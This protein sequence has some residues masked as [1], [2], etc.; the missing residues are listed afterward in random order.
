MHYVIG[1]VHG[2]FSDM[3]SLITKI[4][5]MDESAQFIFVG[6]LIDRGP[7]VDKV[8]AWC[9]E[10]ITSDGKYQTVM[11]NH[12]AMAY[13]WCTEWLKW[14][15][16][17]ETSKNIAY[18]PP[19]SAYDLMEWLMDMGEL[20]IDYIRKYRDFVVAMP[21]SMKLDINT[22][23]D[24]TVTYR[25]VHADY[26]Y[27]T[28]VSD[29]VQHENNLWGR[30]HK[31]NQD[32]GEII[33]HGH[34]PT[35]SMEYKELVPDVSPGLIG[36]NDMAINIDGGCVFHSDYPMYPEMLCAI[37]LEDMCEIYPYEFKERYLQ[38]VDNKA[39]REL[40]LKRYYEYDD[41]YVG[42]DNIKRER[43]LEILGK[44]SEEIEG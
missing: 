5:N 2:C 22:I 7:E 41:K 17:S 12:E 34:T 39:K 25:I 18:D 38:L 24:K 32:S 23:W 21:Y 20:N 11:G 4:N 33:I 6:D 9:F 28:L 27:D 13:D 16:Y 1:D 29:D 15:D 26:S 35:F 43:L 44:R 10:N 3:M 14:R 8:L 19:H 36:Y 31:G 42:R 40:Q 30:T 37:R